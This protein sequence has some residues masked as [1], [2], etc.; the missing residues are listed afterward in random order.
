MI[1]VLKAEAERLARDVFVL[2]E[3]PNSRGIIGYWGGVRSDLPNEV[4]RRAT[5]LKGR[6]HLFSFDEEL[7][8]ELG[9][10]TRGPV[11]VFEYE[12]TNGRRDFRVEE[13]GTPLAKETTCNGIPLYAHR[14]KC[15]PPLDAVCLFGSR[16]IEDWLATYELTR[17]DYW[18]LRDEAVEAYEEFF[19]ASHFFY[20][21]TFDGAIVLNPWTIHWPSDKTY[22][23]P[24]LRCVALTLK[25]SEPWYE[26]WYSDQSMGYFV[27]ERIT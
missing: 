19:M 4:S 22:P 11:S 10:S 15:V 9:L 5:A 14:E 20:K 27:E 21:P 26:L 25:D 7:L 3:V 16:A 18:R 2:S 13:R 24:P 17:F 6:R 8:T 23:I 1:E 12:L